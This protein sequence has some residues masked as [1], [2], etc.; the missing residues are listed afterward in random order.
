MRDVSLPLF[1]VGG[2][3][4]QICGDDLG[5]YVAVAKNHGACGHA[6]PRLLFR[7][8]VPETSGGGQ[9]AGGDM[10][11]LEQEYHRHK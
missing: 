2:L 11:W 6:R 9:T 7:R 4:I 10:T 5:W 3:A 8:A 1:G